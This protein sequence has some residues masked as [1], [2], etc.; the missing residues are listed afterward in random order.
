MSWY[1]SLLLHT[2]CVNT[3]LDML[4][5]HHTSTPSFGC[6]TPLPCP[7]YKLKI[8]TVQVGKTFIPNVRGVQ[9]FQ[10]LSPCLGCFLMQ[11]NQ[12]LILQ[13]LHPL[14]PELPAL[15]RLALVPLL[16][17]PRPTARWLRRPQSQRPRWPMAT[18][19]TVE[20]WRWRPPI[21]R[22]FW[23]S[24]W[25]CSTPP[26]GLTGERSV[27]WAWFSI[28]EVVRSRVMRSWNPITTNNGV[29]SWTTPSCFM[30]YGLCYGL[31]IGRTTL[32]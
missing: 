29:W 14:H 9:H 10:F 31:C 20:R 19:E 4:L 25:K 8:K 21:G 12:A 2:C 28:A 6:Q 7:W 23:C 11:L 1:D 26:T 24:F 30:Q 5:V 13:L 16:R 15:P 22:A 17:P 18:V 32:F 27:S 3:R